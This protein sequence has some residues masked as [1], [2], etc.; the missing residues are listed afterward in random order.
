MSAQFMLQKRR[1]RPAV[2]LRRY[3]AILELWG[4]IDKLVAKLPVACRLSIS[5]MLGAGEASE[6]ETQLAS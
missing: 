2:V 4:C 6:V 3:D 5:S 1:A